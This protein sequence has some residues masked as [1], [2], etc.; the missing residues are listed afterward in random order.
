MEIPMEV[1]R[2]AVANAIVHRDYIFR[3]TSLMVEIFEDRIEIVNPGR[4]P[5]G[6]TPET[7]MGVS[8]R[9]N[10]KIADVFARMQIVERLGSG[11]RRMRDRMRAVG[12]PPPRIQTGP[13]FRIALQR[14]PRPGDNEGVNEGVNLLLEIIGVYPGLRVPQ[15]AVKVKTSPKNIERWLKRLK[16]QQK[17]KYVGSSKKGGYRTVP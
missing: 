15:L 10:E 14:P 13:F 7:L 11:L 9:R 6:M 12:L 8:L 16:V 3:G 4:V 2:E 1:L 17:I 5:D